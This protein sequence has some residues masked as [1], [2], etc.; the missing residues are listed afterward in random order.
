MPI[1]GSPTSKNSRAVAREGMIETVDK[2]SQLALAAHKGAPCGLH[3]RPVRRWLLRRQ[4]EFGVLREYRPLKLAEPLA[5]LDAKLPDQCPAGVLVGL[6]RVRLTLRAVQRQHQLR[7]QPLPV[8]VIAD[9]R[10]ELPHHLGM[11]T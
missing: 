5:R 8:G 4:V 10:L 6:Q 2:L 11:T 7:A 1:P 3:C 9:Q